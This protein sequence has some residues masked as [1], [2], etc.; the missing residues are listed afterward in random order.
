MQKP[1]SVDVTGPWDESDIRNPADTVGT[2]IYEVHPYIST[3][4]C[5]GAD[6]TITIK[7]NPQ[8]V[9]Q[10]TQNDTAVC[11]DWG[12]SASDEHTDFKYYRSN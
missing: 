7:V 4:G 10:V 1:D 9:M 2:V 5:P 6:T 11:F 8:P 12:Y 3:K